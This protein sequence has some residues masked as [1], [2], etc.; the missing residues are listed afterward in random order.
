MS[1]RINYIKNPSFKEGKTDF[2]TALN[3]TSISSVTDTAHFG[4]YSLKVQKSDG[5]SG[6]GVMIDGYRIPI[7]A[8]STYTASAYIKM[9][10]ELESRTYTCV[11][12]WYASDE[13]GSSISFVSNSVEI[14]NY[15]VSG[16]GFLSVFAT[17]VAPV[18]ATHAD[19]LIFQE[20]AE[21]DTSEQPFR[22]FYIDSVLFEETAFIKGFFE[23]ITQDEETTNVNKSL[24][25]VP[26]PEITGMELN[27]DITLNGLI[28]NTI[29]EDGVLWVCT[30]LTG[31]WG[32]SEPE[33]ANIPRGLGDG[34]YDVRGRYAARE[35][36]FSGVFLPPNKELISKAREKLISAI[37]LVKTNGWLI[38][39]E[40][41]PR[42]SL[43]RLIDRPEIFTVNARG[44]TEFSFTLRASD[45]IK[46]EWIYNDR[47]GRNVQQIDMN[48][49][50]NLVNEG[51]S[52]VPAVFEMRGPMEVGTFIR[53]LAN[54]QTMTLA[55]RL[56]GA[57]ETTV[58]T[59]LY[60]EN[61]VATVRTNNSPNI[62]V[63][64]FIKVT[65]SNF[66]SFNTASSLVTSVIED[67]VG[68]NF[69]VS[70]LNE[71][72][73][74]VRLSITSKSFTDNVATL[75]VTPDSVFS[76]NTSV[77]V[78]GIGNLFDGT[79]V[80]TSAEEETIT[81]DKAVTPTVILK[82]SRL[83]NVATITTN[84]SLGILA[85]DEISVSGVDE[86]FDTPSE[87]AL[88]VID[89]TT[90]NVY[91]I[92][93]TNNF[94]DFGKYNIT[95]KAITNGIAVLTTSPSQPAPFGHNANN[96]AR[97]NSD[98]TLDTVF[99][100]KTGSGSFITADT[101]NRLTASFQAT[102]GL[103]NQLRLGVSVLKPQLDG[104]IVVG[105][106]FNSFNDQGKFG[107]AKLSSDG[108]LESAYTGQISNNTI[109]AVS[110]SGVETQLDD[111]V[112]VS[113][114]EVISSGAS[115]PTNNLIRRLN[116]SGTPDTAFNNANSRS[117]NNYI[118][119][120]ALQP[121]PF[122][123]NNIEI[124]AVGAFTTFSATPTTSSTANR[125]ARINPDGTRDT[126]FTTANGTGANNVIYAVA[127]QPSDAAIVIGGQFTQFNGVN[128]NRIA[129]LTNAGARDATFN[130]NIGTG[131]NNTISTIAIQPAD[132]KILVGGSFSVFNGTP[133]NFI[134]RLNSNG[135]TDTAFTTNL[136][137]GPGG[138]VNSIT[139]Q[140]DGKIL[141]S[142]RFTIFGGT[143][144]TP[145]TSFFGA[146]QI[147]SVAFGNGLWVAGGVGGALRTSTNGTSWV[148]RASTFG[149]NAINSVAHNLLEVGPL[150][151]AAGAAG[152]LRTSTDGTTWVTRTSTFGTS[153]INSVVYSDGLWVAAGAAG[154]LRTSTDAVTWV[155]RTSTFGTTNINSVTASDGFYVAGGDAGEMRTS[156][157]AITWVTQNSKFDSTININSVAAGSGFYNVGF[158]AVGGSSTPNS[159][160]TITTSTDAITW[161]T[162]PNV[163]G[164]EII[165]SVAQ[166]RD[167]YYSSWV[168]VSSAGTLKISEDAQTWVTQ[169]SGFGT[170]NIK[171][172]AAGGGLFIAGGDGGQLTTSTEV[173]L[174]PG[175]EVNRIARLNS[176][177]TFD[178]AFNDSIGAGASSD[179][180]VAFPQL[181]GKILIGG[182]FVSGPS[183]FTR[184]RVDVSGVDEIF[185]VTNRQLIPPTSP[186]TVSY[187]SNIDNTIASV[188]FG[189][190]LWVA[191]GSTGQLRTST[192]GI[193]WIAQ[194]SNFGRTFIERVA[195]GN[196][197]WVA[198]GFNGQLRTST[199]AV[200]WVTRTSTFGTSR[201]RDVEF[202][203]DLWVAVGD[204]GQLRTSTD[205]VTW[206]TRTSQF[207]ATEF[208][209]P[210]INSVAFGNGVWVASSNQ[211]SVGTSTDGITWV[212]QNP[213]LGV[214]SSTS[215]TF[216]DGFF[217]LTGAAFLKVSTD[218]ITWLSRGSDFSDIA[219]AVDSAFGGGLWMV[220]GGE[221]INFFDTA[222]SISTSTDTI[223]WVSRSTAAFSAGGFLQSVAFG[224]NLWV[225]AGDNGQLAT[226]TNGITWVTRTSGFGSFPSTTVTSPNA[227][228]EYSV[229]Q[230]SLAALSGVNSVDSEQAFVE[231]AT[232]EGPLI[233]LVDGDILEIDTYSQEVALNGD[234]S[235][236]R[237]YLETL[238][239]WVNLEKGDNL[240]ELSYLENNVT[241]KSLTDDVATIQTFQDHNFRVG[242]DVKIQ[243]VDEVFD[244]TYTITLIDNPTSFSFVKNNINVALTDVTS[245]DSVVAYADSHVTVYYRS[246]WLG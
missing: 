123:S 154:Q 45:P 96:I 32:N 6:C 23:S 147:N 190:G 26:Y 194:E 27:A 131:A 201:I 182:R 57:N 18:G 199:D 185:N 94:P 228:A 157:D 238:A 25:P 97:V 54:Q 56:R 83:A 90:N 129:R 76:A 188:A 216:A 236:N 98:G 62:L 196:G 133:S 233:S 214:T 92:R 99:S 35:V 75:T 68:G 110:V 193:T 108:F 37:D 161:V 44:R 79:H 39:D 232:L 21:E 61:G 172:V 209:I 109:L 72:E 134:A 187:Y 8:G 93:Y 51:N 84:Q 106:S 89:D 153:A 86:D 168:A 40:E 208:G 200:T 80:L 48:T 241:K 117:A 122:G 127:I 212:V 223:T 174:S 7:T 70:Y 192:N 219:F 20:E 101:Q 165:N 140:A 128:S 66:E 169:T 220:V 77:V 211:N 207:I 171:T 2:W 105:G 221:N 53:N 60:R 34:S 29:D 124:V 137:A 245:P 5:I 50:F 136:G 163:F 132:D 31:W 71:G 43:V 230:G 184:T 243:G 30:D 240:V 205:A 65:G 162:Q 118:T 3:G 58:I 145:R 13:G 144:W 142:G 198:V 111:K 150:W 95:N 170:S 189:N 141:I 102:A 41:P 138:I 113:F 116:S 78:S 69:Q 191:A 167:N 246:G 213:A 125:I 11:I 224:G 10:E 82:A 158:V 63:D 52:P 55:Q 148:T 22:F 36:Q 85:G 177:G 17:G 183:F 64:D 234:A 159:F 186:N 38:V 164:S 73:D 19:L 4:E 152:T 231:Y 180:N 12:N 103:V 226:S 42:A 203:N 87:T 225:A 46:Y 139:V 120:I 181:D 204:V 100:G 135:T 235:G 104:K 91:Q 112:V 210:N 130:T 67:E 160:G 166:S 115:T 9:P 15:Q 215:L 121:V 156:T 107:I 33:V 244:G 176:D 179:V 222:A 47:D 143:V 114:S 14:F 206:V 217:L 239:E 1:Q 155:T 178:T 81:Y 149:A 242:D 151:V 146:S 59:G 126:A 175:T 16:L 24:S 195:F 74:F 202:A 229:P 237:F 227:L 197:L 88:S 218:G 119:A 173:G 49:N 28:F